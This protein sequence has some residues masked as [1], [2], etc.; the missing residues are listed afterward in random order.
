MGLRRRTRADSSPPPPKPAPASVLRRERKALL[1]LREQR[2]RDLGG[3]TVELYRQGAYR[4]D[5]VAE[6]CAQL[7]GI[8]DRIATLEAALTRGAA[9]RRCA[10]GTPILRGARF[11]PGCGRAVAPPRPPERT[12]ADET[13]VEPPAEG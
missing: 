11:C 2:L 13:V 9:D 5:L 6:Q 12:G 3:L 7:V 10:C 4:E 8:E 1:R